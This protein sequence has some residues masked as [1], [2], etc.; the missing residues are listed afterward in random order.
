MQSVVTETS[1]Q[2]TAEQP[3][4]NDF[5]KMVFPKLGVPNHPSHGS[6]FFSLASFGDLDTSISIPPNSSF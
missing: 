4:K 1:G 6:S 3:A 2:T 5:K